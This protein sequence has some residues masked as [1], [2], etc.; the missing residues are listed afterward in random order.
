M[1]KT[2]L[3]MCVLFCVLFAGC[4]QKKNGG[5][6]KK[7]LESVLAGSEDF[8]FT[9]L[10]SNRMTEQNLKEFSFATEYNAVNNFSPWRYTYVDLDSDGT[11]ELV[12]GEPNIEFHLFLRYCDG[13]VY[14][15]IV[16]NVLFYEDGGLKTDGSFSTLIG[17]AGKGISRA[18]FDGTDF[19]IINSAY[20][21]DEDNVYELDGKSALEDKVK[22]YFSDW[23]NDTKAVKFSEI[24]SKQVY[25]GK[26]QS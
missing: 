22:E 17:A 2:A 1:K 18:S 10:V 6:A 12:V 8:I 24:K 15:Y 20:M 23:E 14:G 9:D 11:D 13:K 16:D 5:A 21:N 19:S 25:F 26:E 4:G 7:A 3:I